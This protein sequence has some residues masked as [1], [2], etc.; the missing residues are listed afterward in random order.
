MNDGNIK[1]K[2]QYT[3]KVGVTRFNVDGTSNHSASTSNSPMMN[4]DVHQ[5]FNSGRYI[6]IVCVCVYFVRSTMNE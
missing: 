3:Y 2:L 4:R 6:L 1:K 5:P